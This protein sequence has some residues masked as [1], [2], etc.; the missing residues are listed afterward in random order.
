MG[1]PDNMNG[2]MDPEESVELLLIDVVFEDDPLASQFRDSQLRVWYRIQA[3][4]RAWH[5]KRIMYDLKNEEVAWD[6]K[7]KPLARAA[8][9]L[10]VLTLVLDTVLTLAYW[11]IIRVP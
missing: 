11:F 2:G 4:L 8:L 9:I 5:P 10:L 1:H 6:A 3:W 7:F